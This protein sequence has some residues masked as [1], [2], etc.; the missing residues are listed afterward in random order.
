MKITRDSISKT[1]FGLLETGAR[2]AS[3]FLDEDTVVTASRRFK[4]DKRNKRT[5]V[6]VTMGAPNYR[7]RLFVKACKKAGE[8][9]PV[10]K[11]QLKFWPK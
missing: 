5:E 4:P 7:G 8:P 6:I 3:Y 9:F 1:V 10:R 11:I 2:K